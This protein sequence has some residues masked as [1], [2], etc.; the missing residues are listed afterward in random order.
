METQ[1][2]GLLWD[3]VVSVKHFEVLERA[4]L[5]KYKDKRKHK[6]CIEKCEPCTACTALELTQ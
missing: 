6:T 3:R 5:R 4:Q 2:A 1:L